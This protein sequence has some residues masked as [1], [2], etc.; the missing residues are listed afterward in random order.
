MFTRPGPAVYVPA[1]A[2]TGPGAAW[3][4]LVTTLADLAA[5]STVLLAV[6]TIVAWVQA[7]DQTSQI[8]TLK[9]GD[10]A[11]DPGS[12]QRP[13]DYNPQTP[14]IWAKASS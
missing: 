7:S 6:G 14:K 4:P 2:A 5:L 3:N 8:W 1:S 10:D 9:S 12:V 13:D 11:T